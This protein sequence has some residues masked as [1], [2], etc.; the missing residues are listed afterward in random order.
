LGWC[1]SEGTTFGIGNF[2]GDQKADVWCHD[3]HG[4]NSPGN[5]WV[6]TSTG[7]SF[8]GGGIWLGGWCSG[9][10][11]KLGLGDLDGDG[12]QDLFCH[13]GAEGSDRAKLK[14][15]LAQPAQKKF[16]P[17]PDILDFCPAR[18]AQLIAVDLNMDRK[19]D[20]LCRIPGGAG[21]AGSL[22]AAFSK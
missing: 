1:F 16:V 20:L 8:A 17:A 19:Q 21:K 7:S 22:E 13:A 15:A 10:N 3:W 18:D 5:T 2:D 4:P 6:G 11:E 12:N 9:S 14:V